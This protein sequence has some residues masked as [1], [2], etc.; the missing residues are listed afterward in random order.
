LP[1]VWSEGGGK[2]REGEDEGSGKEVGAAKSQAMTAAN[3][4]ESRQADT[5]RPPARDDAIGEKR[6]RGKLLGGKGK[7]KKYKW[8][9]DH[10][11]MARKAF[12]LSLSC[13]QRQRV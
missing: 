1:A 7:K 8:V 6:E 10:L 13:S 9:V 2:R 4:P 12:S 3:S 11:Y 5:R